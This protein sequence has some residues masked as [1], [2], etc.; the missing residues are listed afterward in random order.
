MSD[1]GPYR[2]EEALARRHKRLAKRKARQ[3]ARRHLE[4]LDI[5]LDEQQ[6]MADLIER[7]PYEEGAALLE[8][9]CYDEKEPN[10]PTYTANYDT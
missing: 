4:D 6:V 3:L 7:D 5:L 2:Y 9:A 10:E 1:Y 8:Q